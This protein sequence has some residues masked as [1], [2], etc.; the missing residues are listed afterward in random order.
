MWLNKATEETAG[1]CEVSYSYSSVSSNCVSQKMC[2]SRLVFIQSTI[3]TALPSGG[4]PNNSKWF[5][6]VIYQTV[7]A[8]NQ[9][10]LELTENNLTFFSLQ[11]VTPGLVKISIIFSPVRSYFL[12]TFTWLKMVLKFCIPL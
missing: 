2:F 11:K 9:F 5:Q 7:C 1:L 6:F 4:R 3:P 12:S 8:C 10:K